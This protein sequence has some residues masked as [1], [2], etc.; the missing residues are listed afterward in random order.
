ML[1]RLADGAAADGRVVASQELGRS[2]QS[3]R[4]LTEVPWNPPVDLD[5]FTGTLTAEG[6]HDFSATVILVTPDEFATLPV[7]STGEMAGLFAAKNL[8]FAQFGDGMRFI[9]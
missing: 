5:V 7:A 2:G 3:A 1:L 6:A 9:R 4:F 8:Y